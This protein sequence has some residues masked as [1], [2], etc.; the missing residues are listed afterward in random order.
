MSDLT[1]KVVLITGGTSG[2]GLGC[3]ELFARSGAKVVAMSIQKQEGESAAQRL[4]GE[5][6]QC[7]FHYGDV[8]KEEDVN[9]AVDLT[10]EKFG[11]LDAAFANA[12]VGRHAQIINRPG[13]AFRR[14]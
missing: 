1:D 6:H 3:T 13:A 2:I 8:S 4:T 10:V 12:G 11:R 7:L 5:G 9:A 14:A